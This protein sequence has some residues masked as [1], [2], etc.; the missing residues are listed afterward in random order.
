MVTRMI[1]G[2]GGAIRLTAYTN[3]SLRT[4]MY[5]ALHPGRLFELRMLQLPLIFLGAFTQI[6]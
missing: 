3:Y 2:G 5:C 1:L 4:L 6:S